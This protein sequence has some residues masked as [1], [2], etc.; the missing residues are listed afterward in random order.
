M[1]P[2]C[3]SMFD[4]KGKLINDIANI[5]DC[6]LLLINDPDEA[7]KY[8]D[9]I[10]D[11]YDRSGEHEYLIPIFEETGV[12]G[13][14]ADVDDNYTFADITVYFE[15]LSGIMKNYPDRFIKGSEDE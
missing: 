11:I 5:D 15:A 13:S 6:V 2:N 12:W 1:I 8:F 14:Y 9:S 7:N 10:T 3:V 4:T